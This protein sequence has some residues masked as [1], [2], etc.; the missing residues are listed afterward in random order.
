MHD[1]QKFHYYD[2]GGKKFTRNVDA[3][4]YL[5]YM[6]NTHGKNFKIRFF[7]NF[8]FILNPSKYKWQEEPL[9]PLT[10][11][12]DEHLRLLQEKYKNFFVWYSGGTD[13][14]P[15]LQ[16]FTRLKLPAKIVWWNA[17]QYSNIRKIEWDN[18]INTDFINYMKEANK[19]SHLFDYHIVDQHLPTEKEIELFMSDFSGTYEAH[20]EMW[21]FPSHYTDYKG[22]KPQTQFL[23][24]SECTVGGYEK[25]F[26]KIR[27]GWWCHTLGD[28][29]ITY[30]PDTQT[31]FIWFY[32]T[33]LIP[34]LHIKL[35]WLRLKALETILERDNLPVTDEQISVMQRPTSKY[36]KEIN[37]LSGQIALNDWLGRPGNK[38]NSKL[39][40]S[41]G[42]EANKKNVIMRKKLYRPVD[43][44][45]HQEI[46]P[47]IEDKF[48]IHK[49]KRILPVH[50]SLIR[51]KKV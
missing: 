42:Y 4:S 21:N 24:E 38:P 13:S 16:T 6:N 12:M 51:L 34:E 22:G 18:L 43:D 19:K 5:N 27:K 8:D 47:S 50:T 48:L 39:P 3:F 45:W 32:I 10:Y 40:F 20:K 33:D 23:Q 46:V 41:I 37:D 1:S 28:F 17:P 35:T 2:V 30:C 29:V 15:M 25:P 44:F 26:L 14:H 9:M 49:H 7:L 11:Y 36:Y 31:D